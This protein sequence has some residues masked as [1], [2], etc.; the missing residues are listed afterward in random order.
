MRPPPFPQTP[1]SDPNAGSA[2]RDIDNDPAVN[3]LYVKDDAET[4]AVFEE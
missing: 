1:G 4:E 2:V 3:G